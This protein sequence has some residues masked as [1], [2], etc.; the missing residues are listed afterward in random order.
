[1]TSRTTLAASLTR[2]ANPIDGNAYE[3]A[4]ADAEGRAAL[5]RIL[6]D[7]GPAVAAVK[8]HQTR[9]RLV[10]GAAVAATAGAAVAIVGL[11]GVSHHG[12]PAAWAVTKNP[13]GSVTVKISDYRDPEGLQQT[14]REAGLRAEV[15]TLPQHCDIRIEDPRL[16]GSWKSVMIYM[17]I[18]TFQPPYDYAKLIWI[19]GKP[20]FQHMDVP[21]EQVA[22][23]TGEFIPPRMEA[24]LITLT[25][26]PDDLPPQDTVRIGFPADRTG[27]RMGVGVY[28][29]DSGLYCPAALP[30][31]SPP[32][33]TR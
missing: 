1:M 19:G 31:S 12:A 16:P 29:T 14:L 6:A 11:P 2:A 21:L 17:K 3:T 32:L 5:D 22:P 30:P 4:W 27:Q 15:G 23:G 18:E 26:R 10:L 13:D 33:P 25:I 28:P 24:D 9:R 20:A 7:N 8:P